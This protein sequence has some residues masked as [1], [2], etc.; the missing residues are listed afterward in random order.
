MARAICL[1]LF[2]LWARCAADRTFWTAGRNRPTRMPMMAMTT[3]SSIRVKP[4]RARMGPPL[5]EG[6]ALG[7]AGDLLF[8]TLGVLHVDHPPHAVRP[9][10]QVELGLERERGPLDRDEH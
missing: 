5:L 8:P 3:S 2:W 6:D 1:R 7:R 4:R 10:R 9:G